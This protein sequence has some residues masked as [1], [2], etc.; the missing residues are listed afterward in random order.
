MINMRQLFNFD[1]TI[2][3]MNKLS[4]DM[5]EQYVNSVY[6]IDIPYINFLFYIILS[7][8]KPITYIGHPNLPHWIKHYITFLSSGEIH[9]SQINF[10]RIY[11][12]VYIN[13]SI[14]GN[15]ILI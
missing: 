8:V 13:K 10:T 1:S 7:T 11:S 12:S 14:S 2:I 9:H 4:I 5:M 15:H 3:S 6:K